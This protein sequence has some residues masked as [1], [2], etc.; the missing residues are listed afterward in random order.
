M[1][2]TATATIGST[3]TGKRGWKTRWR[4]AISDASRLLDP[5]REPAPGDQPAEDEHGEVVDAEVE[6]RREHEDEHGELS[7]L[8]DDGPR[9]AEQREAVHRRDLPVGE[10]RDDVDK[11]AG[12]DPGGAALRRAP[13]APARPLPR[14]SYQGLSAALPESHADGTT[15][16]RGSERADGALA[17]DLVELDGRG[18]PY[19]HTVAVAEALERSGVHV[20]LHTATDAELVP[21]RPVEVC[22]CMDWLRDARRGRRSRVAARFLAVTVPHL[23]RRRGVLHIQGP[24]KPGLLTVALG[25]ADCAAAGSSSARTTRSRAT[26][27]RRPPPRPALRPPL[28]RHDRLLERRR[29][30]RRPLGGEAGGSPLLQHMPPIHRA[31]VDAWHDRWAAAPVVLFAGQVRPDKRLDVVIEASRLW[32][33]PRRLAIVGKDLG[34]AERCRR[35][36]ASVGA[37]PAWSLGYFR[38]D[39]FAAALLAADV[40]VCPYTRASQS[41]ILA[42]AGQLGVPS[43]ASDVGGLRELATASSRA[44]STPPGSPTRS[45]RCSPPRPRATAATPSRPRS[46]PTATHTVSPSMRRAIIMAGGEGTRLRPYT[47]VLP[48]PLMPIGDRPV[49]DIVIRQLRAAG[50][51]RVTIATG[52]LAELIEAFF[53]DGAG[54][55]RADRLLP[56]AR[57]ARHGRRA[58]ADRRASTSRSWS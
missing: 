4:W 7:Q 48:K 14:C 37:D 1:N 23:L 16:P 31:Q 2:G 22:R 56:R 9:P 11:V 36:A 29:E 34:D 58:R 20:M 12:V 30:H 54:L 26:A 25:A 50:F 21:S 28:P 52:Y 39:D 24:F 10:M 49:L 17:V 43:I 33:Q 35:L 38:L 55:R 13:G 27:A 19:Q 46:P 45:T 32:T 5:A 42:L 15:T 3:P 40:V 6:D 44:T 47:A 8:A 57:A 41:G 18:G 51:E 53:R